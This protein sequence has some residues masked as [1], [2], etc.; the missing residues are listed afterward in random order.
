LSW[1]QLDN[2][3]IVFPTKSSYGILETTQN[4]PKGEGGILQCVVSG[5]G[6]KEPCRQKGKQGGTQIRKNNPTGKTKQKNMN[7][8]RV[9]LNSVFG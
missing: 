1:V 5:L 3:Y 8:E 6:G 9:G 4:G 7:R 2:K